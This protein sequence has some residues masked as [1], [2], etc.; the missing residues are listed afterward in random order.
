METNNKIIEISNENNKMLVKLL[1]NND[2]A[3]NLKSVNS[4]I[5]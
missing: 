5:E 1:K 3:L 4:P 2:I